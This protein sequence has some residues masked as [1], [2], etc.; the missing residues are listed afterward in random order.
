MTSSFVLWKKVEPRNNKLQGLSIGLIIL[1]IA[2]FLKKYWYLLFLVYVLLMILGTLAVQGRSFF[3]WVHILIPPG[4]LRSLLVYPLQHHHPVTFA[5][6][7]VLADTIA[8]IFLFLPFGMTIFLVFHRIFPYSVRKIL[9]TALLTGL[10]LSIGIETFQY[11][12]PKRVPSAS[13]VIANTGGTVFGCYILCFRKMWR[14]IKA[15]KQESLNNS[16]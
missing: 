1:M 6:F 15:A 14:E 8:N 7:L 2:N 5:K 12:V 11:M 16:H 9:L 10:I 4:R 3:E 13:D